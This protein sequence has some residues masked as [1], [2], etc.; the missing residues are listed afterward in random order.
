MGG[1]LWRNAEADG[2]FLCSDCAHCGVLAAPQNEREFAGK[3]FEQLTRALVDRRVCAND[4]DSFSAVEVVS[5]AQI[6]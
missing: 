1:V 6:L 2:N 4:W 3:S 5:S